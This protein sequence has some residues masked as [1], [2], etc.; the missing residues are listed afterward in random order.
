LSRIVDFLKK[1]SEL[2]RNNILLPVDPVLPATISIDLYDLKSKLTG[3][4]VVVGAPLV[5]T[6]FFSR[7]GFDDS[8]VNRFAVHSERTL[9]APPMPQS[10]TECIGAFAIACKMRRER[11]TESGNTEISGCFPRGNT[12]PY[13]Y[14]GDHAFISVRMDRTRG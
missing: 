12:R 14:P 8:E 4:T 3:W 10:P 2:V 9:G 11:E 6:R 7:C 5:F 1:R 13:R